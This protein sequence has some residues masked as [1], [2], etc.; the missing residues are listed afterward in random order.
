MSDNKNSVT[1]KSGE[2]VA[3]AESSAANF[4]K[5]WAWVPSLY[6][7]EGVPYVIVM[8]IAA[9]MYKR[10]G[11]DNEHIALYTSWLYLPWVIKPFWSPIVDIF[12]SKRWWIVVMQLLIGASLAGVA[13]TIKA[14]NYVIWTLIFFWLMAFSSATHDIAADGFYM[15]GLDER[16]QRFFVGVRST[17]YRIATIATQGLLIMFAGTMEAFKTT[18]TAWIW[19]F[20]I[21]AAVLFILCLYH[22]LVFKVW[23][24]PTE[25]GER[26]VKDGK[27]MVGNFIGTF[28]SFF[29]K[30]GI[31]TAIAFMLLFRF[32][33]ALLTKICPLFLLDPQKVGGLELTTAQV[34]F[35]QG[36]MGVIGLLAGGVLGGFLAGMYGFRRCLWPMV[37]SIT[38]PDIVYVLLAYYQ[39]ANFFWINAAIS[40]EQFGYGF[41]FTAYMLY[42][43][44]FAKGENKT[45][46]YAFC[47]GFMALS[48]MMPGLTAGKVQES[49]GYLN[50]F[51]LVMGLIPLTFLVAW[52]I[53]RKKWDLEK[54]TPA[55]NNVLLQFVLV[56]SFLKVFLYLI[57]EGVLNVLENPVFGTAVLFYLFF[58]LF[59]IVMMVK[60]RLM[61][62]LVFF[63][64]TVIFSGI[65]Y[66]VFGSNYSFVFI[67][68]IV[69]AVILAAV[70]FRKDGDTTGWQRISAEIRLFK[71][72]PKAN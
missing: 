46:H 43:L 50:F 24:K 1:V 52:F 7:A 39:P 66:I 13:M 54:L 25:D 53:Y 44:Q 30:P 4:K 35:V 20:W 26:S 9:V 69:N 59:V 28:T 6:F 42:M 14:P 21:A 10:L 56:L 29:A 61:A 57:S 48:M 27:A 37:F 5:G 12:R 15:I 71:N 70:L 58:Q 41:G 51:N 34:G 36:T 33:E 8:T 40:V 62:Y 18:Q 16:S 45:A 68:D 17:F 38:L 64:Q 65:L 3:G 19:T 49:I 72:S 2:Q 32:P 55:A 31:L 67:S 22:L 11:M 23:V 60:Q 63:V 47:T